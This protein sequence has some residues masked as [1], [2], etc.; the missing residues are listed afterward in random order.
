MPVSLAAH[1]HNVPYITHDSDALPGLS[2]R[3]AAKWARYHATA[4][5][6]Q[7]YKYPKASVRVVGVPSDN[8]FRSYSQAEQAIL[9]EKYGIAPAAPVILVTG[10]SN[11]ARR[12]NEAVIAMLPQL[13]AQYPDVHV[14]HQ[15]GAG[16]EDQIDQLDEHTKAHTT[17]FDFTSELFHM[18][19]IADVVITRAG[20]STVAD[21]GTQ[22]KACVIV[23]NPY[24]TG[25]HQLKNA[26][27]YA[28][29]EAA[30]IVPE[31]ELDTL[32][33]TVTELLA[34]PTKRALLSS[35]L[36]GL[37]PDKSPAA[38]LSDLLEEI[39]V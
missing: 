30:V 39:A 3:I 12:L 8:R 16:N 13:V 29:A 21:F 38:A 25:G 31:T 36:H 18:S 33:A 15:L 34:D 19:A 4:M 37:L 17:F 24:L 32:K 10:G 23:P 27:V 2:N 35:N 22:G 1:Q 9:R 26:Q 7:Y 28:D 6:A 14:L 20:A 11:G 5:P